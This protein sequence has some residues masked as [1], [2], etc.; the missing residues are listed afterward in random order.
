MPKGSDR[1]G[2]AKPKA[3]SPEGKKGHASPKPAR[4][5]RKGS[6]SSATDVVNEAKT[7]IASAAEEALP[8]TSVSINITEGHLGMTICDHPIGV[9]VTACDP[10]DL[11]HKAGLREGDV[12]V[13]PRPAAE[14]PRVLAARG[15]VR[16]TSDPLEAYAH[17]VH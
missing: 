15:H 2:D 11:A 17:T 1:I 6:T 13:S 12:L 4:K 3:G 14:S 10:I 7:L 8:L 16:G 5:G 9:L